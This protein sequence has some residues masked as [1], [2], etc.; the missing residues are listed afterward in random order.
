MKKTQQVMNGFS[1]DWT[2]IVHFSKWASLS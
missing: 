2:T 1:Q